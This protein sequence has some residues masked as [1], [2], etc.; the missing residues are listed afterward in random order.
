ME[1]GGQG[2]GMETNTQEW[3]IAKL[4]CTQVVEEEKVKSRD[5]PPE[6]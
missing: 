3:T 6:I 5:M 4:K 2:E 1:R